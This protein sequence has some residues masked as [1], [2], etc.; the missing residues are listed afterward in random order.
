M[1][2]YGAAVEYALHT[3]LNLSHVPAG[4]SASARDLAEFQRLPLAYV[5]KLLT[6]L[7]KAGLVAGAEGVRGGWRL[8]LPAARITLLAAAEAVQPE[9]PLF[10]CREIRG[11]CALWP[12]GAAPRAATTG[13]CTI[14]AAMLA[15]EAAMR[16]ELAG[17]TLADIA[18]QVAAK[19]GGRTNALQGWFQDRYDSRR[20]PARESMDD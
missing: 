2:Y 11:R 16:R 12:D 15:A 1:A 10:E 6:Q 8:A 3:L 17:R 13:V 5:R 20:Q 14:H 7:E 18:A 9:A 4:V 19:T